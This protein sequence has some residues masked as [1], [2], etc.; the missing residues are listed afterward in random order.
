M[1]PE[2]I[3]AW[4]AAHATTEGS[5]RVLTPDGVKN[6]IKTTADAVQPLS[7]RV[8]HFIP[9]S[10]EEDECSSSCWCGGC[11]TSSG[12]PNSNSGRGVPTHPEGF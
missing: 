5:W 4:G 9:N 2:W 6:G 11:N 12:T 8:V 3:L 1:P 10:V 7:S